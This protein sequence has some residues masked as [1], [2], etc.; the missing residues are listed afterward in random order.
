MAAGAIR[1]TTHRFFDGFDA[2]FFWYSDFACCNA[3]PLPR[4]I[5][6]PAVALFWLAATWLGALPTQ[7]VQQSDSR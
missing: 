7:P 1:A 3:V 5:P 4:D 6:W 2:Y